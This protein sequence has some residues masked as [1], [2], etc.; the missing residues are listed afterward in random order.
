MLAHPSSTT[1]R[2][3]ITR[4]WIALQDF[5]SRSSADAERSPRAV[6]L[7]EHPPP[8]DCFHLL[9]SLSYC[10][11]SAPE[12]NPGPRQRLR[13]TANRSPPPWRSAAEPPG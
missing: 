11:E 10:R 12:S 2:R 1:C 6:H 8:G 7:A 4:P 3:A 5:S 9:P 13:G